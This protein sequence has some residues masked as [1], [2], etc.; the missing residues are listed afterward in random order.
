MIV[1]CC[2]T[3]TGVDDFTRMADALAESCRVNCP[4]ALL[5]MDRT[6][7]PEHREDRRAFWTANHDKLK[8]W[9]DAAYRFN[10]DIVL[11]DADTVVLGDLSPAFEQLAE[12]G[13]DV[14]ITTRPGRKP[15]NA[16]VVYLP[17]GDAGRKFMDDWVAMDRAIYRSTGACIRATKRYGGLNQGSLGDVITSNTHKPYKV[18]L[19]D[20]RVWNAVDDHWVVFSEETRVLHIK[21]ALRHRCMGR[22]VPVFDRR[23]L[24]ESL[25]VHYPAEALA[26][27]A[28]VTA[29]DPK[30][31][32]RALRE[33]LYRILD[34][35]YKAWSAFDVAC[36]VAA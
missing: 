30:R 13:S 25:C 8:R 21:G 32:T 10:D 15:F 24:S 23:F 17:Q 36:E 4:D 34:K 1:Y 5:V 22:R 7:E 12:A 3:T 16:G 2:Y 33:R 6:P 19:L 9:H 20:G 29:T 31:T 14:G 27:G 35:P 26:L 28:Y 11:M 18:G